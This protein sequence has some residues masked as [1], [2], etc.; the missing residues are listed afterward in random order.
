MRFTLLSFALVI[1][2]PA[3]AKTTDE[4]SN[5]TSQA[6]AAAP[7]KAAKETKRCRPLDTTGTRVAKKKVC[8]TAEQWKEFDRQSR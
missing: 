3:L 7:D 5:Q 1:A 2:S 4:A 8:M 6:P